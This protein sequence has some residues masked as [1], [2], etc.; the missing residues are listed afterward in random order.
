M[1]PKYAR[2]SWECRRREAPAVGVWCLVFR[3]EEGLEARAW[4][5]FKNMQVDGADVSTAFNEREGGKPSVRPTSD[6]SVE[7]GFRVK[8]VGFRFHDLDFMVSG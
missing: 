2:G 3:V 7:L 8:G 1:S 4:G 6:I 5:T